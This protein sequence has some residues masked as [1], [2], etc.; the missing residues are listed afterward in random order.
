VLIITLA[1]TSI[2][3]SLLAQDWVAGVSLLVLWAIWRF[4]PA[5]GP[6]VL[7]LALTFQWVQVNI[8]IYYFAL[9]GVRVPEMD[10]CDYRPFVLISLGC[11]IALIIGLRI[12]VRVARREMA[13]G[14]YREPLEVFS[15]RDLPF[16]YVASIF[17]AGLLQGIAWQIPQL[18]QAMLSL[19]M[20]RYGLLFL[21]FRKLLQSPR[22][23][24]WIPFILTV[25]IVL[26]FTGFFADFREAQIMAVLA[27]LEKFSPRQL[28]HWGY[29][30][31]LVLVITVSGLVWTGIKGTFRQEF[32]EGLAGESQDVR[33]ERA[34]EL[35]SEWFSREIDDR[36]SDAS[37]M[38]S[39]LWAVYYPSLAVSRVPSEVPYEGGTIE[40]AA[41]THIL[42]P[43]L[44]FP[45]KEE[46]VSDSEK[47]RKYAGEAVAGEE[48]GVSIAFGY[49]AESYVDFGVP[50][51]FFPPLIFAVLVGMAYQMLLQLIKHKE[52]SIALVTLVFWLSL[53]L[54]ERSWLV[55]VG[56]TG[57]LIFYVGGAAFLV[58]RALIMR[59]SIH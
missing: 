14:S 59:R 17:L 22:H 51:M 13:P 16:I 24:L 1:F 9:T 29:A 8:A 5:D 39:R 25:E 55:M 34:A 2:I 27:L 18:T 42:T 10:N 26:G 46:M 12:G 41:V 53:Y 32:R 52:I 54:F 21:V 45:E 20:I 37:A 44:I 36:T 47:V 23:A 50:L 11:L 3:I 28:L 33:A 7:A 49:V 43:R 30:I 57:T 40:W 56:L 31:V 4:L 38:V 48:Q 19:G 35:A 15:W 6:P 58:D